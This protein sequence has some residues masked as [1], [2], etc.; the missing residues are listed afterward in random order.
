MWGME[1]TTSL[2]VDTEMPFKPLL[3]RGL[4]RERRWV[5]FGIEITCIP[6]SYHPVLPRPPL[7]VNT[8]FT[9]LSCISALESNSNQRRSGDSWELP[10]RI[11]TSHYY[12][13]MSCMMRTDLGIT[14]GPEH[15]EPN[16]QEGQEHNNLEQDGFAG[17]SLMSLLSSRPRRTHIPCCLV[18]PLERPEPRD[19]L[20]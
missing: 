18:P 19:L 5:H 17:L 2:V 9:H 13:R 3:S 8:A 14:M 15:R 16:K 6:F 4:S 7:P 10:R 12:L 1:V 11:F 20:C